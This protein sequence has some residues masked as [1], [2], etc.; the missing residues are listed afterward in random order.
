[1][2]L[3]RFILYFLL[4][5][6]VGYIYETAAM[7][8]WSAKWENRGFLFGPVI[9]IYGLGATFGTQFFGHVWKDAK[10]WQI[11]LFCVFASAILEYIVHYTM[12]KMFNQTWW[13]YTKA[14]FNIN[15]RICLPVSLGFGIAGLI[16]IF[17]I[18]PIFIPFLTSL[19][20]TLC[21][22]LSHILFA[23]FMVDVV[24][25]NVIVSDIEN[26]I[27]RVYDGVNVKMDAIF[28]HI[29]NEDDP[30]SKHFY[31][32]CDK[33]EAKSNKYKDKA[34]SFYRATVKRIVKQRKNELERFS[35]DK[36][37]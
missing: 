10:M 37:K 35:K 20:A 23:I 8:F 29:L 21:N 2:N 15:G 3:D 36:R 19:D 28:D 13:D 12:E 25:T 17:V 9:P 6:F 11:F 4:L 5:S 18:N 27:V 22:V 24:I 7:T 1:M 14:P 31:D 34:N 16:I 32:A 26:T 30:F 33:I